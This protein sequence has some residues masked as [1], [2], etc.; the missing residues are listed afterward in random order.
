M[1]MITYMPESLTLVLINCRF[2]NW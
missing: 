1:P 2:R